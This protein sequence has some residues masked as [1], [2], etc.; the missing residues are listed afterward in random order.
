MKSYGVF[1]GKA[2]MVAGCGP[3]PLVVA[4]ELA[5]RRDRVDAFVDQTLVSR[6]LFT[7]KHLA[8]HLPKALDGLKKLAGI[9]K[10]SVKLIH[11]SKIIEATGDG[12]VE[13]V[14]V[15]RIDAKGRII[16]GSAT[17]HGVN[18]LAV[19][20]G[21]SPNI[22]LAQLAACELEHDEDK[23]G[24]T[25]RV[26]E[27]MR[28]SLNGV[29][30]A[31]EIT[32]V[33]GAEKSRI[34]GRLAG[35]SIARRLG[36]VSREEY[37]KETSSLR[38]LRQRELAFGCFINR[39]S[40]PQPGLISEIDDQTMICRCEDIIMGD[41]RRAINDGFT[42]IDAIKK[43]TRCGMGN[44]QGRTCGPILSLILTVLT[45]QSPENVL[46]FSTRFPVKPL[47]IGSLAAIDTN[48]E[49]RDS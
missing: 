26:D 28:T 12:R 46:P 20:Y 37:S 15:G 9:I 33:A 23:G 5:S 31:G 48:R 30:A 6:K 38:R 2:I 1:P 11:G 27:A 13:Q 3:L 32:G 40:S 4:S 19:G 14:T 41:V 22:E 16:P 49:S 42:T 45:G 7:I 43:A 39:L 34:E 25:V 24:W 10:S 18:I 8:G 36:L 17:T 21:F 44:C 29:C 35:L 47:N